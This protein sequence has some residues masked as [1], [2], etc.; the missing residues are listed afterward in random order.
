MT[1][2]ADIAAINLRLRL[3]DLPVPSSTWD[4]TAAELVRP[5]LARQREF[6]RRL[7]HRLPAVD[8]RIQ[9]FLD[10]YL[11]G[12]GTSPQLPRQTLVLDQAGLARTLSL[13]LN[14]DTFTSD[15]L[16]SYR[17]ANGILHNPVNDRR[18]TK[19][20]FHIA[21]GGLPIQDD[22]LAVPREVYGRLLEHAFNPPPRTMALP[23]TTGQEEPARAWVS[24]L[25]RPVVVPEVPGQFRERSLEIRFFAPGTLVANLDFVE[26]IFGNGG[27]PYL[28]ENDASLMP[29]AWTGHT[30]AVILAP[31]LTRLT[32]KE[33]GLPHEKDATERQRRDGMCWSSPDELY[34]DGQ[35][36]KVCARDERGVIVTVIADNYF[37]YCKKEV[38]AQISYAANLLGLVEEEHAGGAICFP[39]YNLGQQFT[40]N[41]ADPSYT[42]ADVIARDPQRFIPQ[43]EGHAVDRENPSVVLVPQGSTYS[44]RTQQ[45]TWEVDGIPGR[46]PLRADRTYVGPDGYLV[47]LQHLASDG[48]QWTL[49]GTAPVTTH[50]HK[51]AT[52]SGGGKS[53]ISKAITDAFITGNAYVRDFDEDMSAVA[54]ILERDYSTRFRDPALMGSDQRAVLSDQRSVGSVIKLLS[55]SSDYTDEYNVWLESIP[56]HV[57]ELVFVVKRFYRPEWGEDWAS[58]FTVGIINGRK[59]SSLRLDG[60]KIHVNMLRVGF[61]PDGSWRL[62]G[63]RHDFHPAAKIQT[64]DDITASIVVPPDAAGA[65][66][67]RK[68]VKNC[69]NLL[70]QRPDDAK[71]RGYDK[72]AELD[73]A[74][75]GTFLSNFEPLDQRAVRAMVDNAVEFSQFSAPMQDLLRRFA[76]QEESSPA[77][78][79]SSAHTRLVGGKR[80]KNP[81]YLQV[82]PDVAAPERSA[83]AELAARLQRKLPMTRPLKLAV[84]VVAAGRRNNAAEE[85]VPPLCAYSPL[86]FMELP[87]LFME[88]ISSMT[89][90]SPST[91]GA[92][93][94]GAMTKG[95]FN[96][97]PAVYDLNAAFLSF[98]LT[99]YDGWLS[100]AGVVGPHVRV[101]H[102][103][104]L[105]VPE[106]FSRMSPTERDAG[107]LIA[108]GCLER[109]EDYE[110][111][112]ELI[113][114]SRLGYRMTE[115]FATKYFG[116]IFLHPHAVFTPE[117]LRPELQDPQVFADS[118]RT[119]S[120]THRR[121]ARSYIE[122]GTIALAVPPIRA[123][124]EIMANGHT[125]DGLTLDDAPFR[126][127]FS[128]DSVLASQWYAA[129][130]DALRDVE[131]ARLERS[132]DSIDDFTSNELH[133]Q[134][135][136]RLG[137]AARRAS[138]AS[139]IK[140][141][142][143]QPTLLWGTVGRQ[144]QWRLP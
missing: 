50:C 60:E 42:L 96:A 40:D 47:Q 14:G 80:S 74:Q 91:T 25:L 93:S 120:T 53:E 9:A 100:S 114:A 43:P 130:I 1:S 26:G 137:L 29:R 55:P 58:H 28:P 35:A 128:R 112:G 116:R 23:Y 136:S 117:M 86:H 17:L 140:D 2:A 16:S 8:G 12:T 63:L 20:V 109:I 56:H 106:V 76:S 142:Q 97:L 4:E 65:P 126:E 49:I 72:Q 18:T 107:N 119:I 79:V 111:D 78:V 90:K 70:F 102:D 22:K 113:L 62:F 104:S 31:H 73:I 125:A 19:G 59:G 81:R 133:R 68:F 138:V 61:A 143:E 5:L 7:S 105:L 67:S 131:V 122:D 121:V 132:L 95:P 3:L 144:V 46:I 10:S 94:E 98:A 85:G 139:R 101:D 89:G 141:L 87:E 45:V 88:F 129:R 51:P 92:G 24:L 44:L 33:L 15:Y 135:A 11:E 32:K 110:I 118:V 38:K 103:I 48:A 123:L 99:G 75:P 108:D 82:R 115:K 84:D 30:G 37:G 66:T 124:L 77:W 127:T 13:P 52:V 134:T 21:E 69:E 64:E 83:L 71:H 57:K 36:F 54:A 34:N 41:Y 39:R 6:N 27:D